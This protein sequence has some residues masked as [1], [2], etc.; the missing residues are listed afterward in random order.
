MPDGSTTA[1][2]YRPKIATVLA[3]GYDLDCFRKDML[4]ALTVAIVALPL[5]MAI[6][7][8]SGVSPERG[9]YAA[10]I[11]GFLVSALGGSR[12]Q[13]GGP[14]GRSSFLWRL[15]SPNSASTDFC[16]RSSSPGSC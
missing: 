1:H 15:L 2:I 5:S 11:G 12:Y 6:A 8:A 9:L 4:A 7:V 14:P 16:S 10:V 13:I 3:E